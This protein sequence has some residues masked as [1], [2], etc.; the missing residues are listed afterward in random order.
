MLVLSPELLRAIIGFMDLPTQQHVQGVNHEMHTNVR[1]LAR[2]WPLYL[3]DEDMDAQL[4]FAKGIIERQMKMTFV[5]L[6]VQS[7]DQLSRIKIDIITHLTFGEEFNQP[8]KVDNLPK[9]VTHLTFGDWYDQPVDNL[10][11][12]VTHL[13][14]GGLFEHPLNELPKTVTHLT[15]GKWFDQPVDNLHVGVTHLTF[16]DFFKKPV[17]QLPHTVTHITFGRYFNQPVD[18]LPVGVT[19]LTFGF[20]FNH[21]VPKGVTCILD[22]PP[23]NLGLV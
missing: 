17:N 21:P 3:N 16:G 15:F 19:H 20:K 12:G 18:N 14:F 10:P 8:V 2:K 1:L 4:Q 9:T 13:T 22:R 7:L 6:R 11:V 23:L 5:H